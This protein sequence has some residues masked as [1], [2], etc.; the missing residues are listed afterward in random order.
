MRSVIFVARTFVQNCSQLHYMETKA[1][2][3]QILEAG[4]KAQESIIKDFISRIDELK[5][6]GQQYADEQHDSG[7]QSMTA[8]TEEQA[9][10]MTEQLHMLQEEMDKLQ[11][12]SSDEIH[13]TVH[14]GSVVITKEQRFF[15]SVSIEKFKVNG[16][17]YFGVST[18][19]P[20]Y[21][22]MEGKRKGES[23]DLKGRSFEILDLY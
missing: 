16:V 19:A 3:K 12:I 18:K 22:A 20:I 21:A 6:T 10:L 9:G 7:A 13:E 8:G 11:R 14:L 15:V 2:K 5:S 17:E 4:M 1:S 23:F